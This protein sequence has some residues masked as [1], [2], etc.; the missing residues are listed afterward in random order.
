[1]DLQLDG[2]SALITGGSKGIGFATAKTF[3]A[4]GVSLHLASRD[5]DALESAKTEIRNGFDVEV[6][7]YSLDLG[8]TDAIDELAAHCGDVDILVNNAGAIAAG[9]IA[10]IDEK[11][12]RFGWD[13]K[14]FG[15]INLSRLIYAKMTE[16]GSGVIVNVCGTAG[17]QPASDHLPATTANS[18][19][20]TL[21]RAMGGTSLDHGVRVVGINPGDCVN[22]RGM[23]F[24]RRYAEK[25]LGDADRWEE[26]LK[27]LPG[28]KAATSDDM[29]NTIVF[30]ASARAGYISGEVLTID[31]GVSAGRAVI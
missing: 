16:R 12:W 17:N 29:A 2:K 18:A 11:T 3:A 25:N 4:E 24:L 22:E 30:L 5:E 6:S 20:I 8:K 1:M 27:D 26:M 19:L 10:A 14:L 31:G 13:L 23:M 28:G 15:Y 21:T 7:T 9:T